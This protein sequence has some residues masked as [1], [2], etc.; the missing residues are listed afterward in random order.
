MKVWRAPELETDCYPTRRK[1]PYLKGIKVMN[2]PIK[3]RGGA[4]PGAGRPPAELSKLIGL[5]PTNDPLVFL[6]AVMSNDDA[7][8]RIRVAAAVALLPYVHA[9]KAEGVKEQKQDAAKKASNGKF[10][11]SKPPVRLVM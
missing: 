4:R 3:K 10:A 8:T 2:I 6:Q 9:K 7:D 5:T 1:Y 11:A